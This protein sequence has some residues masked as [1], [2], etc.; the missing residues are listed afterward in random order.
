[1][2][3]AT[4]IVPGSPAELL[5]DPHPLLEQ[6][7]SADELAV[8]GAVAHAI[9]FQKVSDLPSLR[10]FLDAYRKELLIPVELPAIVSAYQH[11]A[12]GE[13]AELVALDERLA[14]EQ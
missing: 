8:P 6:L 5:G 2:E 10:Q 9:E 7:G 4:N 11:A 3:V 13:T 12:R 14:N 1:M